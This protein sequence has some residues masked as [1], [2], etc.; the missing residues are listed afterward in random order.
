MTIA[1]NSHAGGAGMIS[2][3]ARIDPA[4]LAAVIATRAEFSQFFRTRRGHLSTDAHF[5]VR[6][7][8]RSRA[9]AFRGGA[10]FSRARRSRL[11][12]PE[13]PE[14]PENLARASKNDRLSSRF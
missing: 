6:A 5:T 11:Q 1:Q 2:L 7:I 3:G 12:A 9:L 10:H 8:L 4:F 14:L 13:S